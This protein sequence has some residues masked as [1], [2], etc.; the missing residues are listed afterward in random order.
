[1]QQDLP[2]DSGMT[3]N[4]SEWHYIYICD[5]DDDDDDFIYCYC[6]VVFS[7]FQF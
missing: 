4:S 3:K 1:M 2:A 5:D 7:K 6:T